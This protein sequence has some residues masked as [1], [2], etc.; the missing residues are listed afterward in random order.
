MAVYRPCSC[1]PTVSVAKAILPRRATIKA[2]PAA[3]HHPR[4][5]A[6]VGTARWDSLGY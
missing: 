4:P 6:F 2:L 1:L 5:Y 3:L